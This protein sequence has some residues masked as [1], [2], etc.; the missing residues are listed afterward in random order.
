MRRKSFRT[1]TVGDGA[2]WRAWL[3]ENHASAERIWLVYFKRPAG[4]QT[5]RAARPA[6]LAYEESVEEA[7]C[8]GWI[9]SLV[10]RIDD[11]RYA[12]LFT[13]RVDGT[14][15]SPTNRRRLAKVI[16]DG[17]MTPAGLAKA[18]GPRDAPSRP[19]PRLAA[20]KELPPD[21]SAALLAERRAAE[22]FARLAPAKRRR[23]LGW[24]TLAKRADTRARRIA[25]AVVLLAQHRELGL[26]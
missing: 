24:I 8:F 3:A 21:F 18:P 7:L 2:A 5:K 9:D 16:A 12:R 6:G 13:P 10:K 11:E 4:K 23:Y 25:E 22:Y 1:L 26:K 17:R 15:W 14:T 20:P 19:P